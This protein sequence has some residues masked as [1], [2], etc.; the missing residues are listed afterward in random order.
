MERAG[1]K[2]EAF[3]AARDRWVVDGLGVNP[4]IFDESVRDG[5]A[6]QRIAHHERND[7]SLAVYEIIAARRRALSVFARS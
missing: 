4:E 3:C 6:F 7:V 2:S 5:L 1:C